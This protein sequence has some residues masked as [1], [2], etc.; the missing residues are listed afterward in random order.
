MLR[1]VARSF[2]GSELIFQQPKLERRFFTVE[3]DRLRY[4]ARVALFVLVTIFLLSWAWSAWSSGIVAPQS[5]QV[6]VSI[7]IWTNLL[8]SGR[9][10]FR[11]PDFLRTLEG[12]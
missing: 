8:A 1:E 7:A 10:M 11:R 6:I 2:G 3:D 4:A 5:G 12:C 9:R